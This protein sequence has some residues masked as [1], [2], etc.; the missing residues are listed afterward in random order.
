[1]I[2]LN[3]WKVGSRKVF[4]VNKKDL[5]CKA[6]KKTKKGKQQSDV[7]SRDEESFGKVYKKP[8]VS[9]VLTEVRSLRKDVDKVLQLTKGMSLPPGLFIRIDETFSCH[10]CHS[11]PFRLPAIFS[12]CCRNIIG[13]SKCID[14]WYKENTK[15]PLCRADRALPDT[16][17]VNGLDGFINA[18]TPL[19]TS[20]GVDPTPPATIFPPVP[21]NSDSDFDFP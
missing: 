14:H 19:M 13:C 8:K 16:C 18:I 11:S 3:F 6:G 4:A 20:E 2:G 15:C 12:R 10:I 7:S 17:I 9:Q 21:D 5:N 1:M